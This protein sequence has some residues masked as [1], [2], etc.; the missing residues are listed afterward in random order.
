MLTKTAKTKKT[1]TWKERAIKMIREHFGSL[2]ACARELRISNQAIFKWRYSGVP[3]SR[4][5]EIEGLTKRKI[6]RSQLRPDI[7]A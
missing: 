3:V 1:E 2:V 6:K 4:A 7:F 5:V